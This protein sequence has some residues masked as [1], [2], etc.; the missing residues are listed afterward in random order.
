MP[1]QE[2]QTLD[3]GQSPKWFD[4]WADVSLHNILLKSSVLLLN[5]VDDFRVSSSDGAK[6]DVV[7]SRLNES[8]WMMQRLPQSDEGEEEVKKYL[9][10]FVQF[11]F[12]SQPCLMQI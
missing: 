7:T 5:V 3:E 6:I 2:R 8:E 10:F 11:H 12:E 9:N 4:N 1:K